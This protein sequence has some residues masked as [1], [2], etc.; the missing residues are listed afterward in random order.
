MT[1]VDDALGGVV[2]W[3]RTVRAMPAQ[4]LAL[5]GLL[6]LLGV[7][8]FVI[9]DQPWGSLSGFI[10]VVG[11][12]ALLATV[13]FPDSGA[14]VMVLGA[15]VAEWLIAYGLRGS[16]PV[17]RT[18]LL[19]ADLYLVHTLAALCAAM[20]PTSRADAQLYLRWS[21]HVAVTFLA[22]G[23]VAGIG[24]AVGLLPGS[25]T[26]E[27]VGLVGAVVIVAVPVWLVRGR[28]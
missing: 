13:Q 27:L 24:Y 17:A 6:A 5:R 9:L 12:I 11:L 10:T 8:G 4:Q 2:R 19:A 21:G 14:P 23:V 26:L 18:L 1:P 22:T 3:W 20:P 7:A 28:Q 25:L 16:P 15:M